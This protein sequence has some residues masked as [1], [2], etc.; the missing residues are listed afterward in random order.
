MKL[1]P[2]S[3]CLLR[4]PTSK[5]IG[6]VLQL[7]GPAEDY[8]YNYYAYS[9]ILSKRPIF[10]GQPRLRW[11]RQRS[12]VCSGIIYIGGDP[13]RCHQSTAEHINLHLKTRNEHEM[14]LQESLQ[15]DSTNCCI[16]RYKIIHD[17]CR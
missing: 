8:C 4:Y 7:P 13:S 15:R 2:A 12:H 16:D 1:K 3:G 5:W 11:F 9:A 14:Y 10:R 6:S 17:D